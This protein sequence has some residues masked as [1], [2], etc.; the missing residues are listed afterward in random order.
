MFPSPRGLETVQSGFTSGL[1]DPKSFA[2][3][4]LE[5]PEWLGSVPRPVT[6]LF[7]HSLDER[8][9]GQ[10]SGQVDSGQHE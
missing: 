10:R 7:R 2:L 5:L 4:H 9:S 3:G 1:S 6:E 8:V